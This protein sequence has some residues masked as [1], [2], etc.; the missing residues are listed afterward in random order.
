MTATFPGAKT[1]G[2][3]TV[4]SFVF[5]GVCHIFN[6]DKKNA[7]GTPGDMFDEHLYAFHMFMTRE[8]ERILSREEF[9]KE[10]RNRFHLQTYSMMD[11]RHGRSA[12]KWLP[13]ILTKQFGGVR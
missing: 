8:G 6:F 11:C 2:K 3:G 12:P 5:D 9:F 10:W 13:N 1:R 7:L 4:P